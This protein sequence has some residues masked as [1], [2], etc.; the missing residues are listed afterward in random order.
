M[1]YLDKVKQFIPILRANQLDGSD[2]LTPSKRLAVGYLLEQ[3]E[4]TTPSDIERDPELQTNMEFDLVDFYDA[5]QER[6]R[7]H[8][9]VYIDFS[10]FKDFYNS[11]FKPETRQNFSLWQKDFIGELGDY[12]CLSTGESFNITFVTKKPEQ[13]KYTAVVVSP[14]DFSQFMYTR[15]D[16][17]EKLPPS[18]LYELTCDEKGERSE[19]QADIQRVV[20]KLPESM[21]DAEKMRKVA[22]DENFKK[23]TGSGG[24]GRFVRT[25]QLEFG[26][27]TQD[28]LVWIGAERF[29][30]TFQSS[31]KILAG[32][33]F[34]MGSYA[35]WIAQN[36]GRNVA[37][38]FAETTAHEVG[39]AL[40]I[41]HPGSFLSCY[42]PIPVPRRQGHLM[43]VTLLRDRA[44]P[45][46]V[47]FN[48]FTLDYLRY[49]L[50][51]RK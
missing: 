4:G 23:R 36:N 6:Q 47:M 9:T 43:D 31:R 19:I 12:Y 13:G 48:D 40:G 51:V 14:M 1:S 39:H 37:K 7:E 18:I 30:D 20:R 49:V 24:Y 10:N 17:K 2:E 32:E 11:K 27:P 25:R 46:R 5:L 44:R 38:A 15:D 41:S 22:E 21:T 3:Y 8:Q 29:Y 33:R 45:Q 16:L 28:D 42:H 34:G 26:N 50:G 35:P